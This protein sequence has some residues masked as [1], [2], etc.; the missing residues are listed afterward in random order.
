MKP[1]MNADKDD[2]VGAAFVLALSIA[3]GKAAK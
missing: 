2:F 3:E 1:Q